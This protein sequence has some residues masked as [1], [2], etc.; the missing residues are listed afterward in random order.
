[1]IRLGVF[2]CSD[3][4]FEVESSPICHHK[5]FEKLI[6]VFVSFDPLGSLR[7]SNIASEL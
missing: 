5:I 3:M 7:R 6:Y 4:Q 2:V 1:M